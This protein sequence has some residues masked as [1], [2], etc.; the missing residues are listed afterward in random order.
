MYQCLFSCFPQ[1]AYNKYHYIQLILIKYSLKKFNN[2]RCFKSFQ[3]YF[4]KSFNKNYNN[5]AQI[6]PSRK[7]AATFH[8]HI[9]SKD[10]SQINYSFC[11]SRADLFYIATIP[12]V[13]NT[14][15]T[16]LKWRNVC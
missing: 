5:I 4:I 15:P 7:A 13:H 2:T 16:S 8:F 12:Y 1:N 11:L 3:I 6:T 9:F 10:F 14:L